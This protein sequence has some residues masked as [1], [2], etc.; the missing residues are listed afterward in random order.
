M[1]RNSILWNLIIALQPLYIIIIDIMFIM[2]IWMC[3]LFLVLHASIPW[4]LV[5]I[6]IVNIG[7]L[8]G[9]EISPCIKKP[10]IQ[11]IPN[12]QSYY[13]RF[14]FIKGLIVSILLA[15]IGVIGTTNN[16]MTFISNFIVA[17]AILLIIY[18]AFT[19]I[20]LILQSKTKPLI[21]YAYLI[22]IY[23]ITIG[24]FTSYRFK[25]EDSATFAL[26][27]HPGSTTVICC[28]IIYGIVRIFKKRA[29]FKNIYQNDIEDKYRESKV[30][31]IDNS[32][33][34]T[35]LLEWIDGKYYKLMS[36]KHAPSGY[37]QIAGDIYKS[38][39]NLSNPLVTIL[40]LF[41]FLS[42]ILS[43]SLG[44]YARIILIIIITWFTL[45][46]PI[47]IY[48]VLEDSLNIFLPAGR[49]EKFWSIV[50]IGALSGV[51]IAC[52]T[53]LLI[54]FSDLLAAYF[55]QFSIPGKTHL[56][57]SLN[58]ESFCLPLISIGFSL[59]LTILFFPHKTARIISLMIFYYIILIFSVFVSFNA[60]E[61]I[62]V[63]VAFIIAAWRRFLHGDLVVQKGAGL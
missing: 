17:V 9:L 3:S 58:M 22:I 24:F 13:F 39:F 26:I 49:K 21:S 45:F 16:F 10:F 27:N 35:N 32:A 12:I 44:R 11:T 28:I 47:I 53:F 61:T 42:F 46:M 56:T 62:I 8:D 30:K 2:F 33:F 15:M 43:P 48:F 54:I 41:T 40:Y 34:V 51:G 25:I 29:I 38:F 1:R 60:W 4:A 23:F 6:M 31:I 50:I 19:M 14:L 5:I 55:P 18:F 59:L 57:L 36:K 52:Y 20:F 37:H 63:W 7:Y